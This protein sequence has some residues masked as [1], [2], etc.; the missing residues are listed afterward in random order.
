MIPTFIEGK[1]LHMAAVYL[2]KSAII[3]RT[4]AAIS[5]DLSCIGTPTPFC[6][7]EKHVVSMYAN[8]GDC[9]PVSFSLGKNLRVCVA[10]SISASL[11]V[12]N[13]NPSTSQVEKNQSLYM[14]LSRLRA[15]WLGRNQ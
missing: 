6:V 3:H 12:R 4:H 11:A 9:V 15:G 5:P 10:C 7:D 14:R 1:N 2:E 8:K 13:W